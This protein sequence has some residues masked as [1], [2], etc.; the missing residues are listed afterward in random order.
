ML[1]AFRIP[2]GWGELV[3]RTGKEV[4]ADNCL[5][6]AAQLAYYF[7]LALFPAL[8]FVVAIISYIPV[9]NLMDGLTNLLARVAPSEALKLIQ[10]QIFKIAQD[11]AGGLLTLGMIGT[12]WSTS[13]GVTAIID[14]LNTAYDIQESRPWWRVRLLALGLTIA[15]AVFIVLSTALVIAGPAL[16]EKTA[17]AINM[18]PAFEWTWKI[19]QWPIVF[20]LVSLAIAMVFYFAPDAEQQWI[21]ITPGSILATALWLLASLGFRFYVTNFGSYTATYGIIGGVI[22]LL[23][24]FYV[25]ALAVLVG[26]ELN[27]EI[28]HASPYGKDPGEKT[29]GEKKQIGAL[30]EQT[31]EQQRRDGTFRPALAAANCTVD[32]ELPSSAAVPR[33]VRPSDLVVGGLVIGQAAAIAYA[34]M[35][36]HFKRTEA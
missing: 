32:R 15:L 4:I 6:L 8:L 10:D 3:T 1:K 2:I 27:A 18:G 28:E 5:G 24:W 11:E 20:A 16:A 21:W 19:L 30:A 33:R 14:T 31:W 36:A 29:A 13:S 34:K 17:Q 35:R 25:S 22:V 23:L 26:A 7:F 12:L 9:E